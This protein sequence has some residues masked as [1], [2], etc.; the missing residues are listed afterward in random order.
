MK[1]RRFV[2][3]TAIQRN[4]NRSV[5]ISGKN[6][7]HGFNF[8]RRGLGFGQFAEARSRLRFLGKMTGDHGSNL[9]RPGL[10]FGQFAEAWTI[11]RGRERVGNDGFDFWEKGVTGE[12]PRGNVAVICCSF[13]SSASFPDELYTFLFLILHFQT[14][15]AVCSPPEKWRGREM[16]PDSRNGGEGR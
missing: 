12:L 4:E 14:S 6:E 3:C 13:I 10:G 8:Q 2:Q 11:C 9:Q 15:T 5:S 1:R 7:D 16:N